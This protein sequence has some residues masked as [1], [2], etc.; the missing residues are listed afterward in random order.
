MRKC[1]QLL[2]KDTMVNVVQED[3]NTIPLI[4]AVNPVN[5]LVITP[6]HIVIGDRQIR[7]LHYIHTV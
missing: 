4:F 2:I 1:E 5:L 6:L 3:F 7:K